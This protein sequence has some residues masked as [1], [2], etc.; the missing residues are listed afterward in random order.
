M[1]SIASPSALPE[2]TLGN[3]TTHQIVLCCKGSKS[4][5]CFLA[6]SGWPSG[7]VAK[8]VHEARVTAFALPLTLS[9][10]AGCEYDT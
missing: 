2:A 7:S 8:C 6:I 1:H 4:R 10:A 3:R 9:I 5:L